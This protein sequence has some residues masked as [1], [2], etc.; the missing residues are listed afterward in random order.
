MTTRPITEKEYKELQTLIATGFEYL[1]N[2]KLKKFRP[3]KQLLLAITLESNLGLRISDIQKLTNNNFKNGCLEITEKKTGKLQYRELNSQIYNI[4]K[5]YVI[6]NGLKKDE[7]LIKVKT[8]AIQKQL[9]IVTD[10]M[11]LDNI[12]THS[13]RKFFATNQYNLSD[14]NIELVKELLNHSSIATT[15]RY[16]RVSQEKINEVSRNF[17]IDLYN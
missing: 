4:V 15:Q 12:S 13:F 14:N 16:I 2:G 8:R 3:N 7:P 17:F 9:K 5:D 6:E 11:G 1:E 10:Y